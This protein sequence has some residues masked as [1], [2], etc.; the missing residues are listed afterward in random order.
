MPF[1]GGKLCPNSSLSNRQERYHPDF[2][3]GT[4]LP[5][6]GFP[7]LASDP[8]PW[9]HR[10]MQKARV[11]WE[12]WSHLASLVWTCFFVFFSLPRWKALWIR[13]LGCY[14]NP[15]KEGLWL[16]PS[17]CGHGCLVCGRRV[18]PLFYLPEI[19]LWKKVSWNFTTVFFYLLAKFTF[20]PWC[21]KTP[22]VKILQVYI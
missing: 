2:S 15:T 20:F 6:L 4:S 16:I 5:S 1:W 13:S 9:C 19:T 3:R 8:F 11:S 18:T 7:Y 14:S 17:V 22:C 10:S 21:H 12:M